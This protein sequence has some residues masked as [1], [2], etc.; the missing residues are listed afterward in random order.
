VGLTT[1]GARLTHLS[2]DRGPRQRQKI[3]NLLA[4]VDGDGTVP[5][6]EALVAGLPLLRR[7][8]SA[9]IVTPAA[10]PAWVRPL[11]TLRPR[12]I[13]TQVLY[14]DPRGFLRHEIVAAGRSIEEPDA[15]A[16]LA[17]LEQASR[18]VHHALAEFDVRTCAVPPA[19]PLGE[20]LVG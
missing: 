6:V 17:E 9:L 8:M 3:L 19:V 16:E 10:E 13:G 18:Q 7:G 4:A 5:L 11:A 2:P 20:V 12:G 1:T 14:L 15:A